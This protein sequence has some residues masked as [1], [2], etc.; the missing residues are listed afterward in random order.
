MRN[1]ARLK[2]DFCSSR[3]YKRS[4]RAAKRSGRHLR[5]TE[6]TGG[7]REHVR[8][9]P[10]HRQDDSAVQRRSPKRGPRALGVLTTSSFGPAV[11]TICTL[12]PR[13]HLSVHCADVGGSRGGWTA[14]TWASAEPAQLRVPAALPATT[15]S[16]T[17]AIPTR[18]RPCAVQSR[19]AFKLNPQHM[20][21]R[22]CDEAG[23]QRNL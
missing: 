6:P 20:P 15:R 17:K 10:T 16:V 21:F 1:L 4:E 9:T 19:A 5:C 11:E 23:L 18:E 22:H 13:R 8:G 14:G 7:R 12:T 3:R 2:T